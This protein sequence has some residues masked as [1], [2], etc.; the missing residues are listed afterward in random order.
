MRRTWRTQ[1]NESGYLPPPRP[2]ISPQL[3]EQITRTASHQPQRTRPR[4]R[5][6]DY[7]D[8]MSAHR[9]SMTPMIPPNEHG[10]LPPPRPHISP[11]LSQQIIQTASLQPQRTRPRHRIADYA[12]TMSAHRI[13]MTPMIPPKADE[14]Y[15][16]ATFLLWVF[17]DKF[18][19]ASADTLNNELDSLTSLV[20]SFP[21]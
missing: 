21:G 7:A 17:C 12:D 16:V 2:H 4:H 14:K 10:Y 19:Q 20:C 11:Q 1:R 6:A 13:S 8:M 3:S 5:I 9:I 18:N 15:T